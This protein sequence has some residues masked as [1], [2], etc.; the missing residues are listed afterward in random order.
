MLDL[1]DFVH[2][3]EVKA[4]F[5]QLADDGAGLIVVAGL[6][7]SAVATHADGFLPSGRAAIFRILVRHLLARK[8]SSRAIIVAEKRDAARFPR[9]LKH[10]VQWLLVEPPH[11]YTS[12]ITYAM[13]RQPDLLVIDR[14]DAETAPMAL[15]AAQHEVK[16]LSQLDTVFSGAGVARHLLDLG[17]PRESLDVL[18][19]IVTIQR[20]AM[21]C[22]RCKQPVQL[23]SMRLEEMRCRYPGVPIEGTFFHSTGCAGCNHTGRQGNVAAFDFFRAGADRASLLDQPSLLSAQEY[24]LRLAALGY[25]PLDDVAD[26]QANQLRRTY[27]LLANSERALAEA[28]AALQRKL[29]QLEAAN[30][31]LQQRT[32][33]VISLQDIGQTLV[34]STSLDELAGRVCRHARDL[35]GADRAIL[36]YLRTD[37]TAEVLAVS[38]WD[39]RLIHQRLDAAAVMGAGGLDSAGAEPAAFSGDPPGVETAQVSRDTSLKAGLRVPLI[40][41]QE[42]VGLMIVHTS[43]RL[44]FAPGEVAMLRAFAN[45]AAVAIQRTGLIESLRDKIVQLEAAQEELLQ[46]ERLERELELARQVQQRLLPHTFPMMPGFAFAARCEPARRVGGDFYDVI[47]LDADRFGIVIADVSDKGMP[48][49]LFMALTRSLILAEARRDRSPRAVLTNVHRLLLELGEP[50]MFVTVFYGVVDARSRQLTYTRAGHDRPLLLRGGTVESLRGEGTF[51]G[52]LDADLLHLSEESLVLAPKDRVVLYTDGMIDAMAANHQP[53]GSGRLTSLLQ[54]SASLPAD[55]LC[56]TVFDRIT[57]YQGQAEQ[58]DD[59]TMLVVEV[60]P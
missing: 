58:F 9:Q 34:T 16:V 15:Q 26:L 11:T 53:F 52:C 22:P 2:L 51:L 30:K 1:K 18:T 36:Y 45:Q 6:D 5:D 3:P 14:L 33:A 31:V 8:P 54:A 32:E 42:V 24:I 48:A 10:Q 43:T 38:G 55:E 21:L 57:T 20:L 59:M 27:N 44:A 50:D 41:Q 37:S 35:C 46:K 39:A 7:P 13:Y 40:A 28:N 4:I 19:W 29:A 12:R 60:K 17:V 56:A 49:A 47:L 23:D 25:V